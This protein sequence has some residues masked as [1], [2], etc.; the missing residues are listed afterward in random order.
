M[1]EKAFV[2][3]KPKARGARHPTRPAARRRN[4]RSSRRASAGSPKR[5]NVKV[6]AFVEDVAASGGYWLAAA[7]D[8]IWVD[9]NS[10]VGSIG[11]ISASFGFF[12]HRPPPASVPR[13]AYL[14]RRPKSIHHNFRSEEEN[15]AR[16]SGSGKR[17][18]TTYTPQF[19]TS[20]RRQA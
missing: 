2:R 18:K 4:P 11:V 13:G 12:P 15:M 19:K 7:A 1:I 16:L 3:G 20:R 5:R 9:E 17:T 14:R 8:E 6:Y 10:V